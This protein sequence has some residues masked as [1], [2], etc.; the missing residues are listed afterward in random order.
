MREVS[1]EELVEIL[2]ER[3]GAKIVSIVTE[4]EPA[5][6]PGHPYHRGIKKVTRRTMIIGA[7]YSS[8]V[9]RQRF[10]DAIAAAIESEVDVTNFD[11]VNN[12]AGNLP[13]HTSGPLWRGKGAHH[14]S[15]TV[16]HIDNERLY[17]FG[18][19]KSTQE[20]NYFHGDDPIIPER[21]TQWLKPAPD[22]GWRTLALDNVV[23][24][25]W[26]ETYNLV[27]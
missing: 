26:G 8:M 15:V 20:V 25:R 6:H 22:H 21:V 24:L 27:G 10:D 16:R 4:T 5:L 12:I 11:A 19:M 1:Q 9:N 7:D 18:I 2:N 17:F 13:V 23:Q 14:S 3:R